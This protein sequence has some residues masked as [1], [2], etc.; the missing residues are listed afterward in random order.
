MDDAQKANRPDL[1]DLALS[2]IQYLETYLP[3]QLS[4]DELVLIIN[5]VIQEIEAK[6]PSD[7]GKVMKVLL[8]KIQGQATGDVVSKLVKKALQ[9]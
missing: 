5:Q 2:D 7:M 9:P 1:I 8:P 3:R 6:N 4:K